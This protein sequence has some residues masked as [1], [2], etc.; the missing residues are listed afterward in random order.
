M[1]ITIQRAIAADQSAL[2][3]LIRN[4]R[5]NPNGLFWEK[6]IVATQANRLIGAVQIRRHADGSRELGSL[7]VAPD[8]RGAGLAGELI[9]AVLSTETGR[10]LMVTGKAHAAHYARWG[11]V[12]VSA[13]HISGRVRLNFFLGQLIGGAHAV[14]TGRPINRLVILR[15]VPEAG[16]STGTGALSGEALTQ[17]A[18]GAANLRHTTNVIPVSIPGTY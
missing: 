6:F 5:L 7:V 3:A 14:V 17:S 8:K 13:S 2:V 12:S 4:E 15:R 16:R 11:F 9:D 1:S 10:V 18:S